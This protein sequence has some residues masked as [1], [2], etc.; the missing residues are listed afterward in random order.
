MADILTVHGEPTKL[1]HEDRQLPTLDKR[2]ESL[3]AFRTKV[4]E[5][6][7]KEQTRLEIERNFLRMVQKNQG[8]MVADRRSQNMNE[9]KTLAVITQVKLGDFLSDKGTG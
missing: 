2:L 4:D 6:I 1:K 5:F 7:E 8:L 9:I 3:E